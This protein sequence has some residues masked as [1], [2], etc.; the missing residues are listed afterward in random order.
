MNINDNNIRLATLS[1]PRLKLRS[2]VSRIKKVRAYHEK[3]GIKKPLE[4]CTLLYIKTLWYQHVVPGRRK[5][6]KSQ[7]AAQTRYANK[8]GEAFKRDRLFRLFKHKVANKGFTQ[9]ELTFLK[10]FF[11]T[12]SSLKGYSQNDLKSLTKGELVNRLLNNSTL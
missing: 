8:H 4:K 3:Y 5:A 10:G 11:F 6:M 7:R 9:S 12:A 1:W 2:S